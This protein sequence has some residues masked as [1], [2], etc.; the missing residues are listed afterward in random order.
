MAVMYTRETVGMRLKSFC[1]G[2]KQQEACFFKRT[3]T[4]NQQTNKHPTQKLSSVFLSTACK[5]TLCL[6]D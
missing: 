3:Q 4:T 2:D 1:K 6:A 5:H